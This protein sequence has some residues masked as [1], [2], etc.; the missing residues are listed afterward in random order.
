MTSRSSPALRRDPDFDRIILFPRG[1]TTGPDD[2]EVPSAGSPRVRPTA[3]DASPGLKI[4]EPESRR[5][6]KVDL[7]RARRLLAADLTYVPHPSFDDPSAHDAILSPAPEPVGVEAARRI[8][9]AAYR[10]SYMASSR[11]VAILSREQ[12]A[13]LFRR[14]N[15][16]KCLACRLR[17]RI[18]PRRPRV[19]DLDEL[20]RLQHEAL[21]VRN[22][23]VEANLRLVVSTLKR[24]LRPG[25]DLSE[26]VSDG[27]FALLLAVD[28]FDFARGNRF[29]T[30]ATWAII[31]EVVRYDRKERRR[32]DRSVARHLDSLAS[33][34][35]ESER[36]EQD[37]AQ[38]QRGAAVERILGRLEWRERRILENRHGIGG[39]PERTLRQ[40]GLD[41][42]ISKERVR[43][44]EQRAHAKIRGLACLESIARDF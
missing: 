25:S 19:R 18:D 30:Y 35:S 41:L 39:V 2:L 17:D 13:H 1:E 15:Y 10:V 26:R 27:N 43:Q 14:M 37:E 34:D 33:P 7:G 22:R 31:N 32:R 5:P 44:I 42:G 38:H 6:R 9:P 36:Y 8:E 21:E 11:N 4:F 12:E 16:L 3:G 29:S 40:I 20:E 24:R 23:L 28:R